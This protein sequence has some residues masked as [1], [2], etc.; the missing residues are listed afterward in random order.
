MRIPKEEL[1]PDEGY[2]RVVKDPAE[3]HPYVYME[4]IE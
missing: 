2:N 1:T 4:H 3:L